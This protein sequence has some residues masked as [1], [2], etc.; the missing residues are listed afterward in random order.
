M[1]ITRRRLLGGSLVVGAT[2]A[3]P[4]GTLATSAQAAPRAHAAPP[5]HF[6][7][8]LL[9]VTNKV[10]DNYNTR[11]V[12]A[13]GSEGKFTKRWSQFHTGGWDPLELRIRNIKGV[14]QVFMVC[15]ADPKD[16]L[17]GKVIIHRSR[18]DSA[19]NVGWDSGLP[20]FP[21]CIEYLP[22]VDAV[23]VVGTRGHETG[24]G[25]RTGGS[26][27]L[28]TAPNGQQGSFRRVGTTQ[29]FRQAHGVLWDGQYVW[30]YGGRLLQAFTVHR[31]G[32]NIW[33]KD[34]N[35]K[36]ENALFWNG[37]D[38]QLDPVYPHYFW[39][40]SSQRI[41][42][43]NKR[44][45]VPDVEWSLPEGAVKSFSRHKESGLGVWTAADHSDGN[46]YGNSRVHFLWGSSADWA[47][48]IVNHPDAKARIYK[49]RILS[50]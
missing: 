13:D 43:I 24:P 37:H 50:Q 28:Y 42:K 8:A 23:I 32:D 40:T 46:P 6:D 4:L 25:D 48:D 33:L 45:P 19:E 26:Y 21:H 2:A 22:T 31:S 34:A 38:L 1:S 29:P 17:D 11:D 18:P 27:Q 47:W 41:L 36:L 30:L 10:I 3:G 7:L 49:A 12:V 39:A 14:G 9:D 44:G 16:A 15:G 20:I 5:T 35:R